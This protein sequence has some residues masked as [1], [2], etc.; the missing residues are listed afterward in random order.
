MPFLYAEGAEESGSSPTTTLPG[1]NG[2]IS[3]VQDSS[4]PVRGPSAFPITYLVMGKGFHGYAELGLFGQELLDLLVQL[5][6]GEFGPIGAGP[7][8]AALAVEQGQMGY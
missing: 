2:P 7:D 8:A 1:G 4:A 6:I 3:C 5:L